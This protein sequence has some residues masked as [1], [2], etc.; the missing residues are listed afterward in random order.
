MILQSLDHY[1]YRL[2]SE[3]DGAGKPKVP[4][5]GFSEEKIGWIIVLSREG[6][7]I[8]LKSHLT[9]DKKPQPKLMNV[10]RAEKR[11]S[12]IKPNFLWDKTAYTL[13]VNAN[14]DK[15]A[16]KTQPFLLAEDTFSAFRERHLELLQKEQDDGLR[17]L[18]QF[19]VK[20]QPSRFQDTSVADKINMLDSNIV[21][22]LDGAR[23][24]IHESERA[25]VLWAALL[26]NDD[27]ETGLCLIS[28]ETAPIARLHPA[29]KGILGGQSSGGAIVSF[30]KESFES[31]GKEQGAN[32][33][34]SEQAAF[35]YTTVLNYLLRRENRHCLTIGDASTVFWAEAPDDSSAEA[36]ESFFFDMMTVTDGEE[37]QKV[38][39]IL[40]QIAKGR[41]LKEIA[42]NL[43][44]DTRFYILGLAP[45]ASRISIRFW[46]NTTFGQLAQNLAAHWQDLAIEPCPWQTPPSIWRLLIQTAP[47]GKTENISPVLAGEMTRAVINGTPYPMSLLSQLLARIRAD[48]DANGLR[49]AMIKAILARKFRKGLIKEGVPMSL[50]KE[51]KNPAYLLGRMFAVLERIQYQALGDINAGIADRYY[52]SASA[53]PFSVFPRLLVGARHHLSRLRKDKPGLAVNLDKDLGEIIAALPENYPRHFSID[54]QGRFSIGYYQQKQSYFASKE[55]VTPTEV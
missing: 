43:H 26:Q 25:R 20:W 33:P 11:T 37:N 15:A 5:Y 44:A 47:L 55:S 31:L 17:A 2:L 30:N 27:A 13:G 9:T 54:E 12:G 29:I 50:D 41:P 46:L 51:S 23:R 42:P 22:Q 8:D 7:W 49:I 4:D 45:N 48:G 3:T 34:I 1:Y 18:Y 16:A 21:F 36:E 40:Q 24:Y 39:D 6:D 52:G 32:A 14:P 19:L 35:T 10:P 28:G 53:V 38:F